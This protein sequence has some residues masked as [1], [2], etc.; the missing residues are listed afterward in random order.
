MIVDELT[1]DVVEFKRRVLSSHWFRD[2][3]QLGE[4]ID[5]FLFEKGY[6]SRNI[7]IN[8]QY[9]A[10]FNYLHD[11]NKKRD[12]RLILLHTDTDSILQ[13]KTAT[14]EVELTFDGF[15][16]ACCILRSIN[17]QL[18]QKLS[19]RCKEVFAE[20]YAALQQAQAFKSQNNYIT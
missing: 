15:V 6:S 13:A 10:K 16:A 4:L 2:E 12:W 8:M 18:I 7:N 14:C 9:I 11:E 20:F 5:K 1:L 17:S 19:A 3:E